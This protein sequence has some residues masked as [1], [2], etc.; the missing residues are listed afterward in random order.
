MTRTV[1][2]VEA[3]QGRTSLVVAGCSA[4][5]AASDMTP[6]IFDCLTTSATPDQY[7]RLPQRK[8]IWPALKTAMCISRN[9]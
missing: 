2:V 3:A 9:H 1:N 4:R 6:K 8:L 5:I 7:A